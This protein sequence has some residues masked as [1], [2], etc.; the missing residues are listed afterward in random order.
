MFNRK[1]TNYIKLFTIAALLFGSLIFVSP[2]PSYAQVDPSIPAGCPGGPAG[3]PA[4]GTVCPDDDGDGTS[5]LQETCT[6]PNVNEGNCGIIAY[7]V[8]FIR[9]LSAIVGI[10]VVIMITVGGVQYSSARDNPQAAAAAKSRIT[11]AIL[12]LLA[13]LFVFSFLQWLVPGGIL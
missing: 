5:N 6:D 12:A 7:L 2:A 9:A 13:Y 1:N 4:P 3:P 10:V 11:N 8:D